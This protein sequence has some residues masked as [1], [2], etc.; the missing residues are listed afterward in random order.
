[1][2][3]TDS[4]IDNDALK[5][6]KNNRPQYNMEHQ[7]STYIPDHVNVNGF[8]YYWERYSLK[9]ETD[10]ALANALRKGWKAV[11]ISRYPEF[12]GNELSKFFTA[13]KAIANEYICTDDVIYLE[14]EKVLCD[15]EKEY[16]RRLAVQRLEDNDSYNFKN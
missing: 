7:P 15:Q 9:G 6:T 12:G 2:V 14:R 3:K 16:N 11:P 10:P 8:E 13:E 4:R 1:M 5:E